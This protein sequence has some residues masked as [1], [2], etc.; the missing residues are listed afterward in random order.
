MK[1]EKMCHLSLGKS[2]SH[3]R[4]KYKAVLTIEAAFIIPLFL[5]SMMLIISVICVIRTDM[6]LRQELFEEAKYISLAEY[7]NEAYGI[8]GVKARVLNSLSS[9]GYSSFINEEKGG[10]DFSE[11]DL[12]NPEIVNL[13]VVY[14]VKL[15]F[16]LFGLMNYSFTERIIMHTW[17]GYRDG[18]NSHVRDETEV[19]ITENSEVYHMSKECS[20]IRLNIKMIEGS[21]VTDIRNSKGEKYTSCHLCHSSKKSG[22]VYITSDGDRYHSSLLCSGLKR[23]VRAV[24]LYS[25]MDR[26]PCQRCGY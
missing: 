12:S 18:L 22:E 3:K 7:G 4:Y 26:R 15:P 1:K 24:P 6:K 23:S 9:N 10:I 5:I 17:I 21:K 8:D 11:S 2:S 13:T 20:H 25:V 16:D 19:Y 14:N